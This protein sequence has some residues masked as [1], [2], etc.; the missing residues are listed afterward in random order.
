MSSL[1]KS[2]IFNI[3]QLE[4]PLSIF[5]LNIYCCYDFVLYKPQLGRRNEEM[6][7]IIGTHFHI[8]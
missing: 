4:Q 2:R 6:T 5:L 3:L 7:L 8:L 1:Y